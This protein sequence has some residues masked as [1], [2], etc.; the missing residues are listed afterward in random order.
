MY[1][2]VIIIMIII[3]LY[4]YIYPLNFVSGIW[5]ANDDF[6]QKADITG[7]L[8]TFAK[9]VGDFKIFSNLN[10]YIIISANN[11]IIFQKLLKLK[12]TGYRILNYYY[13][14]ASIENYD[15]ND[16]IS[17]S[18]IFPRNFWIIINIE[19]GKM[20]WKNNDTI[21]AELFKDNEASDYANQL[22]IYQDNNKD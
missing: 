9:D 20:I 16:D 2:W 10:T 19:N 22:K 4:L 7:M 3:L 5:K 15:D 18:D 17:I 12:I 6:C 13:Y 21:Y 1:L 11:L 8:V 14:Y